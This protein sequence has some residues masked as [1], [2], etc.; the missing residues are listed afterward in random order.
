MSILGRLVSQAELYPYLLPTLAFF[1]GWSSRLT[2]IGLDWQD[3]DVTLHC[4]RPDVFILFFLVRLLVLGDG[5]TYSTLVHPHPLYLPSHL[6]FRL[7]FC[8]R[9][10]LPGIFVDFLRQSV[11]GRAAKSC[12]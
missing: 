3:L 2:S 11:T 4:G 5:H 8:P 6:P 9:T 12:R 7:L 10:C 1:A